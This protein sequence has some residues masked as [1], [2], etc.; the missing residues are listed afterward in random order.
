M[1]GYSGSVLVYLQLMLLMCVFYSFY[2]DFG[3]Y[4]IS[5]PQSAARFYVNPLQSCIL[6]TSWSEL[7]DQS[8]LLSLCEPTTDFIHHLT[9]SSDADLNEFIHKEEL[10]AY[11]SMWFCLATMTLFLMQYCMQHWSVR[12]QLVLAIALAA[13]LMIQFI[14]LMEVFALMYNIASKLQG[15]EKLAAFHY[16][17]RV[18]GVS[19]SRQIGFYLGILASALQMLSLCFLVYK[20]ILLLVLL[21]DGDS[22]PHKHRNKHDMP[23]YISTCSQM[24]SKGSKGG[25]E[26][27]SGDD[28]FEVSAGSEH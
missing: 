8:Y 15:A 3:W 14:S 21:R 18:D 2:S 17:H 4:E 25:Y 19:F 24:R 27:I 28:R 26:R 13:C 12:C 16:F 22:Y 10:F 23:R 5:A 11:I 6:E 9:N 20:I 1:S 7:Y